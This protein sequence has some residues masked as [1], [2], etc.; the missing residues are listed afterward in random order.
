MNSTVAS[1]S[2]KS[3]KLL[4]SHIV[5][6]GEDRISNLPDSVLHHILSFLPTKY[7]VGTCI[8]SKRWQFMWT[9]ISNIDFCDFMFYSCEKKYS[10]PLE[11][12]SFSNCVERV[13]ILRDAS[14]IKKF[15]LRCFAS[16]DASHVHTWISAAIRHGVQELELSTHST[17]IAL[18][19]CLFIC[20]SLTI[21]KLGSGSILK[22]P[23]SIYFP[24]LKTF[25][26]DQV[27]FIDDLSTQKLFSNC[28]VLQELSLTECV[29]NNIKST[30][31]RV[32][33]LKRLTIDYI[34]YCSVDVILDCEINVYAENLIYFNCSGD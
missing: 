28:P 3:Q 14:I 21:L 29:W 15:R 5:D 9:S 31:I 1:P 27:T 32:P 10:F 33:S 30:T 20:E 4:N 13:L 12:T 24:N 7:A 2:R 34:P 17:N 25:H 11:T 26:L 6:E 8:L 19:Y 16:I 22:V 23:T 18:P